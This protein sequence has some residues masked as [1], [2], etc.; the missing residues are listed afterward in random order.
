MCRFDLKGNSQL[1]GLSGE[2]FGPRVPVSPAVAKSS[3]PSNPGGGCC[4]RG[5]FSSKLLRRE[6]LGV[7]AEKCLAFCRGTVLLQAASSPLAR[8][9]NASH[10]PSCRLVCALKSSSTLVWVQGWQGNHVGTCSLCKEAFPV[11]TRAVI[12]CTF[13]EIL[14]S[15]QLWFQE[16]NSYWML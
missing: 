8:K 11:R 15:Y 5:A 1:K 3:G 13:Q 16:I 9:S 7:S 4:V 6:E 2:L 12:F 10:T 14:A